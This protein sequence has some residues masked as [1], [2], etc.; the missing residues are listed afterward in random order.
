MNLNCREA[1]EVSR[2]LC[3]PALITLELSQRMILHLLSPQTSMPLPPS[4]LPVADLASHFTAK[5]EAV[6]KPP[7][8]PPPRA[9]ASL[10]VP[11][12]LPSLL[13][14]SPSFVPSITSSLPNS[15]M[16]FQQLSLSFP[17]SATFPVS[18]SFSTALNH[19][20]TCLKAVSLEP[21][22]FFV[23]L[24]L[25]CFPFKAKLLESTRR[26]PTYSF[27]PP[28]NSLPLW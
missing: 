6:R 11:Q 13:E 22:F 1:S 24:S 2:N 12:A 9:P 27:C 19:A 8:H 26:S 3:F 23:Y 18:R 7:P 14:D 28:L 20:L 5:P 10:L 25:S 16:S 15:R 21:K 4:S 17:A